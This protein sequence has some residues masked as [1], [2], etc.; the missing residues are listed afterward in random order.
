MKCKGKLSQ[1]TVWY[2]TKDEAR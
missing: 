2:G 1:S